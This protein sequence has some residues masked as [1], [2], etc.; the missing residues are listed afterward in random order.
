MIRPDRR[1]PLWFSWEGEK[2]RFLRECGQGL[3]VLTQDGYDVLV[4]W[5][6]IEEATKVTSGHLPIT[7]L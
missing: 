6:E 3:L 7:L 2:V 4:F 1:M 5:E